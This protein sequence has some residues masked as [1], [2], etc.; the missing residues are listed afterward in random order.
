VDPKQSKKYRIVG[1][2]DY[3][4][5]EVILGHEVSTLMDFWSLGIVAYEFL[6]GDLP[7]NCETQE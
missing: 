2:A 1:T 6:T 3:M 5:P 7:F 4:A